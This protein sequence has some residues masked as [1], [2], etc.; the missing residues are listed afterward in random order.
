[1]G[2]RDRRQASAGDNPVKLNFT[3]AMVAAVL[4][5]TVLANEEC[6]RSPR[7]VIYQ[8]APIDVFVSDDTQRAEVIFPEEYLEGIHREVP[9]GMEFFPTPIK[10][11]LAFRVNDPLYV[12]LVTV[13]GGSRTSYLIN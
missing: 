8:N 7:T 3:A 1:M 9:E 2:G 10:N 5:T 4:S 13:D 11:K 6:N 12:G